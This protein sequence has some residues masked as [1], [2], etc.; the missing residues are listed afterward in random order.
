MMWNN[1]TYQGQGRNRGRRC[2]RRWSRESSLA[3]HDE[4]HGETGCPPAAREGPCWSKS[5]PEAHGRD[6]TPEQVDA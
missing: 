4:D 1:C 2:S 6:P 5:P 3:A